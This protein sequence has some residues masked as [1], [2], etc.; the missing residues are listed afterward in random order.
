VT[1]VFDCNGPRTA[2][3]TG[4]ASAISALKGGRLVVL[5]TDTGSYGRR[6]G[7]AFDNDAGR[8]AAVG[9]GGA[10]ADMPVPVLGW[11]VA[12]KSTAW[13][14]RL[15]H[16]GNA[17]SSRRSGPVALSLGRAPKAPSLQWEPRRFIRHGGWCACRCT[18]VAIELLREVGP[19]AVCRAP[20]I[21]R[22][23]PAAVTVEDAR[24]QLGDLVEVLSR[25]RTL[26]NK[27]AAS[28]I[29]DLTGAQSARAPARPGHG[30]RP[31]A[32]VL[33]VEPE[34]AHGLIKFET[35]GLSRSSS[36]VAPNGERRGPADCS[37][38]PIGARVVPAARARPRRTDR[39]G[40]S[41]TSPTG[42]GSGVLARR[43]RRGSP[44]PRE[45][46]DVH[47]P[48]D[49]GAWV[50]LAM[51]IGVGG[52][53][54]CLASQLPALTPGLR[55]LVRHARRSSSQAD[56]SLSIRA[57]RRQVGAWNAL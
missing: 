54:P 11:F 6:C 22:S 29:V 20:N 40:W 36:T 13:C 45:E 1:E 47:L 30:G 44:N 51:Y 37:R 5:P 34:V 50:G 19:M 28:T 42:L 53:R 41:L 57:D 3:E 17:S 27:Q 7:I 26:G 2:G 48:A 8:R 4:I 18:Q 15:P 56:S 9:K 49:A 21:F 32:K 43:A 12:H 33:G 16:S 31:I 55:L 38:S 25:W 46:R 24:D 52:G 39:G 23:P 14:T 35:V 10:A